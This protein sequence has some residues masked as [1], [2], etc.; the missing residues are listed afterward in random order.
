ML[1]YVARRFGQGII[2]TLIVSFFSFSVIQLIPGDPAQIMLGTAATPAEVEHLRAQLWLD[3]PFPVQYLHWLGNA[4]HGDLGL[5]IRYGEPVAG[6]I[7]TRLP[8]SLYFATLALLLSTVLGT[9][10]GTICALRRGGFVDQALTLVANTGLAVPSFF[11]GIVGIYFFGVRLG[12]LPTYGFTSPLEDPWQ[13]LKQS[14]L[15]VLCLAVAPLASIARQERSAMLEVIHQDYIRT[16]RA[17][18]LAEGQVV[19]RHALRN[20]LIPVVT[21]LGTQ[22]RFLIGGAALIETV[23]SIAGL[24][25]LLVQS[26]L[27]KDF[28][29]VQGGVLV[30]AAI[31]ITVNLVV[32]VAYGY[33]NPRIRFQ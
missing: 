13:G 23:F 6:V 26:V 2:I 28:V 19:W 25:R 15:P 32:D 5:S 4:L 24:G 22:V 33:I 29:V 12:W 31:V 3:R 14:V 10:V 27:N 18:G 17:K 9:L 30:M 1:S 21:L 7:A 20:T 16:A 8:V 11:L